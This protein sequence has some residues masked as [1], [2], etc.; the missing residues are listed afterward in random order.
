MYDNHH[1]SVCLFTATSLAPI[2]QETVAHL[3]SRNAF[4]AP[5]IS[6][7][8]RSL[9]RQSQNMTGLQQDGEIDCS[10]SRKEGTSHRC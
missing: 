2:M 10:Q 8:L 3:R 5:A 1:Y 4:D 6:R 9:G 7:T